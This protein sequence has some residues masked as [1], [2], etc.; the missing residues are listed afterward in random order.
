[1]PICRR[2]RRS[3]AGSAAVTSVPSQRI[4]PSV[5]SIRRLMQRSRVDLPEPDRPMITRNSP[6]STVKLT[7]RS[8]TVPSG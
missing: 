4:V 2:M 1:M 7:W 3:S 6:G 8:A 5:G